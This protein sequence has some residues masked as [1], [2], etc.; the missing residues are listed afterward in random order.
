MVVR[1]N[2]ITNNVINNHTIKVLMY[3]QVVNDE[4][5]CNTHWTYVSTAQLRKHLIL[6][7]H[8]GY[9]PITFRDYL[10]YEKG[11][12][13]LPKKPIILTFDDGY[14]DVY[15]NAYPVIKEFGWNAVTFVLGDKGLRTNTW[16]IDLGI[17]SSPLMNE[18]QIIELNDAGFEIGSHSMSHA[19]LSMI[20]VQTAWIEIIRSKEKLQAI[21]KSE[22]TS[23][24]YP[25]GS[26]NDSVKEMVRRAGYKIACGVFSGPPKFGED[27]FDI[28]RITISGNT[29]TLAYAL[30]IL[31]PFEY[32]EWIGSRTAKSLLATAHK[33]GFQRSEFKTNLTFK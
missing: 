16:D 8:W 30:K 25:F 23:F 12:I 26:V 2:N 31:T 33:Y 15:Q 32:Y 19:R 10:M 21:L 14:A 17:G 28:R 11:E 13:N 6:L 9:T 22:V 29:S 27:R 24:S 7:D 4:R 1:E 20:P 5:L 3:H 18:S